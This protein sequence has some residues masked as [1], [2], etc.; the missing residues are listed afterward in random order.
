MRSLERAIRDRY[1]ILDKRQDKVIYLP[2]T[3]TRKLSNPEEQVQLEAFLEL[4]YRYDYPAH[5]IR[6]CEQVKIGSSSREADIVVYRDDAC[7]DPLIVVECKK[8]KVSNRVFEEAIDQGF[9]YAAVTNAEYVWVTSGDQDAFYEVWHHAIN[10]R[11]K[12]QIGRIP[13]HKEEKSFAYSLRQRLRFLTRHPIISDT[14]IYSLVIFVC[15]LIF[16][17]VAVAYHSDIFQVT[18]PLWQKHGMD[19]SWIYNAI[20]LVST[21]MSLFFGMFFM[22]SHKL[23]RTSLLQ[24]RLTFIFI[25]LILFVP[26]WYM[27]E[28][29]SDPQWWTWAKYNSRTYPSITYIWPYLKAL[30]FQ[31]LAIYGLIWLLGKG[32]QWT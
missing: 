5:K 23:F 20:V 15:M 27:G 29:N 24:K 21:S 31:L 7:K 17:K 8:R 3:K 1:L 12:N 11:Q 22:Q 10:E 28:S 16:S 4:I 32:K 18:K 19:F 6:V 14:L 9:S 25:L 26:A 2:N 30:P 13:K